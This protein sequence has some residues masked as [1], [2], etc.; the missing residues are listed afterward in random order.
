ML[1]YMFSLLISLDTLP[2]ATVKEAEQRYG[3]LTVEYK[4]K[5][6]DKYLVDFDFSLIK[7]EKRSWVKAK[8]NKDLVIPLAKTLVK[9]KQENK[10]WEAGTFLGCYSP[11]SVR[12]APNRPSVHAY[13]L[14]CDILPS[15]DIDNY[16]EEFI[17]IWKENGFCW[18]GDF[19]QPDIMHFSYSWECS[20]GTKTAD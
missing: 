12:G 19:T 14:G 9:L 5:N 17:S 10:L 8:V 15:T 1:D 16:S 7:P 4:W 13:G 3:K 20:F 2:P 18:G 11:R 6:K